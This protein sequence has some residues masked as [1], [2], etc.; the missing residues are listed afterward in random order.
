MHKKG[1]GFT[2]VE[3][4]SVIVILSIILV[5]AVPGI[6]SI[7]TESRKGTF[8]SSAKLIASAAENAMIA[9]Q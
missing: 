4:L 6:M 5:I 9:N 3:L 1:R 7:I 8:A 2:L